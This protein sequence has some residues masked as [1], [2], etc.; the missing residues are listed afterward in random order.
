MSN[1]EKH[2]DSE[3][4]LDLS[5][6]GSNDTSMDDKGLNLELDQEEV[7]S[8][9]EAE[10]A[11]RRA[12]VAEKTAKSLAGRILTGELSIDEIPEAQKYLL[13][14][15]K[16]L[17]HIKPAPKV[18]TV[19]KEWDFEIMADY[20]A[21]KKQLKSLSLTKEQV[22]TIQE[23]FQDSLKIGKDPYKALERARKLAGIDLTKVRSMSQIHMGDS[24]QAANQEEEL[25]PEKV[26]SS[27][28]LERFKRIQAKQGR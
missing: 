1:D 20:V 16:E 25:T 6:T 13:P 11:Q 21:L 8:G 17:A 24:L 3:L 26:N 27:S 18:E 10:R 14:R 5:A 23:E 22:S 15:I 19:K 28:A 4:E 2:A 7:K 12:E 9:P